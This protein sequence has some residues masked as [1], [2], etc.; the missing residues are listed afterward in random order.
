MFKDKRF[1]IFYVLYIT[2]LIVSITIALINF[3]NICA[4]YENN[5]AQTLVNNAIASLKQEK[6][7]DLTCD[8]LPSYDSQGNVS[9]ILKDSNKEDTC[10]VYLEKYDNTLF[11]LALF[12]IKEIEPL[13][14]YAIVSVD[15]ADEYD[16]KEI[17]FFKPINESIDD[18]PILYIKESSPIY[19]YDEIKCDE[20]NTLFEIK[21]HTYLSLKNV[22]DNTQAKI[23]SATV[24][25][26]NI[27]NNYIAKEIN[28]DVMLSVT[29]KNTPLYQRLSEYIPTYSWNKDT[30]I[31]DVNISNAYELGNDYYLV[32]ATYTFVTI[33]DKGPV[34]DD[35]T[36]C[37]VLKKIN[38]NY[39]ITEIS[40]YFYYNLFEN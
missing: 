29:Q 20:N 34:A 8:Y 4:N 22:D 32:N 2:I 17:P 36:L 25:L 1:K 3:Y 35:T 23:K 13:K 14:K 40:N 31:N 21:E 18:F 26:I 11:N 28:K 15:K 9:Y 33:T 6:H 12:K 24:E 5:S 27:Y 19:S 16:Y 38:N 39:L 37:L 7:L 10:K 30:S